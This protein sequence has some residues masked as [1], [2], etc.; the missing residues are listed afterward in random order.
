MNIIGIGNSGKKISSLFNQ[1]SQYKTFYIDNDNYPIFGSHQEYNDNYQ[2][3]YSIIS[4]IKNDKVVFILCGAGDI[5][6]ITL[7]LMED[8]KNQNNS[9]EVLYIKPDNSFLSKNKAI[10]EKITF[11]IL[12]EFVR[13]GMYDKMYLFSNNDI[14]NKIVG[15]T[16]KNYYDMINQTIASAYHSLN[17]FNNREPIIGN[18]L[19]ELSE[20]SRI[21]T[22]GVFDI[23]TEEENYLYKLNNISERK[24]YFALNQKDQEDMNI[25]NKIRQKMLAINGSFGVYDTNAIKSYCYISIYSSFIQ[26]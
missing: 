9:M 13:S 11:N 25:F 8:L 17:I 7:K 24:F 20:T 15:L 22:L 10:N 1:Y 6:G 12:Q 23:L 16:I 4:D 3:P 5:T 14:S 19:K 2:R 26:Q 21:G 18:N